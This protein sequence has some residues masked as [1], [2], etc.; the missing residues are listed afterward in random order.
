MMSHFLN[1]DKRS[2][3]LQNLASAELASSYR[4]GLVLNSP[5]AGIGI[6][7]GRT[8]LRRDR[9]LVAGTRWHR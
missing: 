9:L 7:L 2:S 8:H 3:A 1:T 5:K 4:R 6:L